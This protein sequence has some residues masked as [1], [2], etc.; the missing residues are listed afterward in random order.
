[1]DWGSMP[2][3]DCP[4]CGGTSFFAD[5][6]GLPICRYCGAP[7]ASIGHCPRCGTPREGPTQSPVNPCQP[8]AH[9][10]DVPAQCAYNARDAP[11]A[12]G[13]IAAALIESCSLALAG[14]TGV[15]GN[16]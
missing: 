15:R 6:N 8:Q 5:R 12:H 13:R 14:V 3:P 4:G 16:G 10:V 7:Y 11:N 1:M 9:F 2:P